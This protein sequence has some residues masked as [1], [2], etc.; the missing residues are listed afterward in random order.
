MVFPTIVFGA[1]A[2]V[3]LYFTLGGKPFLAFG[4]GGKGNNKPAWPFHNE[5]LTK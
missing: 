4:K 3:F 1:L 2:A 5:R